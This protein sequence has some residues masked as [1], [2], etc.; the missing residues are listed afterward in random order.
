MKSIIRITIMMSLMA[1]AGCNGDDQP[2]K[3]AD[4]EVF[5]TETDALEKARAVEQTVLDAAA[6]QREQIEQS[7][8]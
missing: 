2:A 6:R 1:I 8:Q 4:S 5:K 7:T 3:A